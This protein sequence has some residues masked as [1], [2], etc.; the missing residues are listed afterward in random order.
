M[1]EVLRRFDLAR[2]EIDVLLWA[3]RSQV[4]ILDFPYAKVSGDGI[5]ALISN[6]FVHSVLN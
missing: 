4:S 2:L 3:T 6:H 1:K 5:M